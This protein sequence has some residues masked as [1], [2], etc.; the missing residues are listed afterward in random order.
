MPLCRLNHVKFSLPAFALFSYLGYSSVLKKQAIRSSETSVDFR[1]TNR[2]YVPKG[3]VFKTLLGHVMLLNRFDRLNH[4][5]LNC[6]SNS[7]TL[8][9]R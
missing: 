7:I 6:T 4:R 1:R 5:K 9:S 8:L 2:R 3:S